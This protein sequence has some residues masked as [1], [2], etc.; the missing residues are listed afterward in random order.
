MAITEQ[1]SLFGEP[2]PIKILS[3][4]GR[5]FPVPAGVTES[6]CKSCQAAIIWTTNPDTGS[7]VP[8]SVATIEE[9]D[10]EC[11]ALSHY[12]DCPQAS[13]WGKGKATL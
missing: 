10:G 8:L 5:E 9:R 6:V 1:H 11:W 2:E 4:R 12:T 3:P 7:N 13:A